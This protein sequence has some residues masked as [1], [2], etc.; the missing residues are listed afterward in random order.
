M[1]KS[2]TVLIVFLSLALMS[3]TFNSNV[4][5]I[6]GKFTISTVGIN[7]DPILKY[8][9]E[10][11]T[12][13]IN[14]GLPFNKSIPRPDIIYDTDGIDYIDFSFVVNRE[15]PE[16][17]FSVDSKREGEKLKVKLEGH[18]SS[19]VLYAAYTFLEK[20]GF[21]FE[22][23]GPVYPKHFNYKALEDYS[24][25]IVAAVK[26]RGIRQHINFTMD[27]SAWS[28]ADAKEYIRNLSRM[29]FNYMT[30]HSYPGQWY[31]VKSGDEISY[32][33][34]FFYGDVHPVPNYKPIKDIAV[35]KKFYCIPEIE[36]YFEDEAKRSKLAVEWLQNV[37]TEVKRTGMQVQFSFEPRSMDTDIT[38]SVETVKAIIEQYPMIDAL[39]FITEEAGGW[40]PRT[41]KTKTE[42]VITE[43]FGSGYLKDSV[44][45]K[46]VRAEQSDLGY[47]YGQVGHSVKLVKYIREN[48][49]LSENISLKLGIY[50]VIPEYARPAFYLARKSLPETEISLMPG[51]HSVRVKN[52][53]AKSIVTTED[54]NHSIIYS[55]IEFDG[56]MY[57]QQNGISGIQ[58]IV[59]Q[60]VENT[61]EHRVNAILYNHWRTAENK[62]TA[63]Y[64]AVSGLYGAVEPGEFY[65]QYAKAYGIVNSDMFAKAM[66]DLDVADLTSMKQIS[67]IGFCW[68][69]RWRNGGNMS[70]YSVDKL[71]IVQK[72]YKK[73]LDDLKQ[74][75]EI[76]SEEGR[77]LVAFLDNRIRTTI[78]YTKVF[79]KAHE[80]ASFNTK[81]E[82]G[83]KDKQAYVQIC[84][85]S[86]A[87]LE[88]YIDIYASDNADRGCSGNLVS[89]WYGPV[90][91]LKFLREKHGG[92]PFDDDVPEG[93]AVDAPPL[94]VINPER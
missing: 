61:S 15:L 11:L 47:V 42:K 64:A 71:Q 25:T 27:L 93:T 65:K 77:N 38:K 29:R 52:S 78:V 75:S 49:I 5:R 67:G 94:P 22:I 69:G 4:K 83:V 12:K 85:E 8:A 72:A 86:L 81:K 19:D 37:I 48:S 68:V 39:E 31:E 50:V 59:E 24:E 33:G 30:F 54:W 40:G 10:E 21:L 43:H 82:L 23:T 16:A 35:N 13:F 3:C 53:S 66:K 9:N 90:K 73:V 51:H 28:L 14:S 7:D 76:N 32:A 92:I 6:Q 55:W 60:A 80:L 46:P 34:H 91:A 58:S 74:C 70:G 88:Q 1:K 45:M 89:M 87:L 17:A 44:V 56:M 41:T 36:P 79:E 62:V 84:N 20:G 26:K 2:N 57:L 18:S 63:R